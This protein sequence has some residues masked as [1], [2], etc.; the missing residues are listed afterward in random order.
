MPTSDLDLP[1]LPSAE[2]I[3][4]REF[5]TIRRGYDPDQVRDYLGAVAVQVESLENDLKD[6]RLLAE[7]RTGA[8][9]GHRPCPPHPSPTP[10]TASRKR[11]AGLIAAADRE[12]GRIVDEAKTDADR[13]RVD[14]QAS[15]EAAKQEG[16][17]GAGVGARGS[18]SRPGRPVDPTR[19]AREPAATDAVPVARAWPMSSR[20]V[21]DEPAIAGPKPTTGCDGTTQAAD[22]TEG[23]PDEL[24][25]PRY[26]DLWVS[27]AEDARGPGRSRGA[28]RGAA[29]PTYR[30]RP[31][32]G[33]RRRSDSRRW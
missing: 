21:I 10:T 25:D 28:V 1:L 31:T 7:S 26:E 24:L 2:Q 3:R 33:R 17:R 27:D 20:S 14:A 19:T 13:I 6:A 30:S 8:T 5:A 18:R 29:S 16:D 22:P 11:F 23:R 32:T 12:A 9:V 4:R 15:A